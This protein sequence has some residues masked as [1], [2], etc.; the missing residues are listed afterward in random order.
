VARA[1]TRH[2]PA[3]ERAHFEDVVAR[4]GALYWA[5]RTAA[6]RR[7]QDVRAAMLAA[8]GGLGDGAR[9]L[10]EI[11]CGNGE[12][13]LRLV[14]RTPAVV[15]AVDVAPVL[16]ATAQ[17]R[18]R[19]AHVACADVG[20]L[21]FADG[22]F[23]A[24][25]GNAVLHHLDLERTV[26]ELARVLRPGGRFCFAEPNMLN[27]HVLVERSVPFVRRWFEG[28]PDETAF[29]RWQLRRRLTA[30]GLVDVTVRPFDFL[31]PLTPAPLVPAVERLGRLLERVP[32]VAELAGSLFITA[33]T[34]P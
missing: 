8:A 23:D 2:D 15:V 19:T 7:R 31:Y 17:A 29:I 33:R 18:A 26:P 25:V 13:T 28:S 1:G 34:G 24:V 27:P 9:R 6:G 10:L 21:P 12:Y 20:T 32:A 4:R 16:T 30:L 5:D 11:G 14:E 22:T 3:R